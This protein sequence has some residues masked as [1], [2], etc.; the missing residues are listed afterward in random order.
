[1]DTSVK[2]TRYYFPN[3]LRWTLLILLLPLALFLLFVSWFI[4][5]IIC[6][7]ILV[8]LWSFR[9]VISIDHQ[10]KL[11][12]DNYYRFWIPFGEQY[13]Y[14]ELNK[15]VV[16]K[17]QQSYKATTRSRDYWVNYNE[18]TLH[19]KYDNDKQLQ[20]FTMNEHEPFKMQVGKFAKKLSLGIETN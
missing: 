15:L 16:T 9:Y 11:I 8:I 20:L 2:F 3:G 13:P 18:Y 12:K 14:N 7:I 17:E 4:T 6:L 10:N 5:A 19:L 1:M